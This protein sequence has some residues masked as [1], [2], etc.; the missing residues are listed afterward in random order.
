MQDALICIPQKWLD[1]ARKGCMRE[2]DLDESPGNITNQLSKN[3][4]MIAWFLKLLYGHDSQH[5]PVK[6]FCPLDIHGF[7]KQEESETPYQHN[8]FSTPRH[9]F[10]AAEL[11]KNP[12][13][14]IANR[15]RNTLLSYRNAASARDYW[16]FLEDSVPKIKMPNSTGQSIYVTSR[17]AFDFAN[18]DFSG[19]TAHGDNTSPP[20]VLF[21]YPKV[22]GRLLSGVD[23]VFVSWKDANGDL[24]IRGCM[25]ADV[26]RRL[27]IL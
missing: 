13:H 22:S 7:M 2:R 20:P 19:A 25:P 21:L 23:G 27:D 15:V 3:D 11:K 24:W 16:R 1:S 26:I 6:L 12:N 17:A 4:T 18:L 10:T 8:E 9:H 14:W 5:E